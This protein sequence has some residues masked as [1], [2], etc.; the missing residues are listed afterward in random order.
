VSIELS[1]IETLVDSSSLDELEEDEEL[2]ELELI[3][4]ELEEDEEEELLPWPSH[5]DKTKSGKSVR[6]MLFFIYPAFYKRIFSRR[7]TMT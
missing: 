6:R 5:A 3:E 1:E 2:D 4:E 7:F